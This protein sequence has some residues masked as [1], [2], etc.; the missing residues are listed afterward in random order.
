MEG[1]VQVVELGE[2]RPQHT[3]QR[4]VS[5]ERVCRAAEIDGTKGRARIA[6][7]RC[8]AAPCRDGTRRT[9]R[10]NLE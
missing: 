10:P 9:V 6:A 4:G 3:R 7:Q 2:V 5:I 8:T 1:A